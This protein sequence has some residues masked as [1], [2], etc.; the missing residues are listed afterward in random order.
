M[1]RK[2]V[3]RSP[4]EVLVLC[5]EHDV[6]AV[7]LRFTDFLGQWRHMTVPVSRLSEQAFE[8]GFGFNGSGIRSWQATAGLDMLLVPQPDTACIDPFTTMPTLSLIC[9]IYDPITRE[10]L[11]HDPRH[12]ARRAEYYLTSLGIADHAY[13]GPEVEFFI[14]DDVQFDQNP[15]EAFYRIDSIEAQW[16]RGTSESP[17]L[18]HKIRHHEGFLPSPPLDQYMDMRSEMMQTMID[19]GIDAECHHHEIAS[20]GQAEIDVHYS[21][22]VQAADNVMM[23]KY[24]VKN[25]ARRHGKTATFMPQPIVGDHGSGMHTHLSFWKGGEPLFAGK[26]YA[27]LSDAGLYALGGILKHAPALLAI[28]NPTTNS[29]KRLASGSEAPTKFAYSQRNRS[30]ACRIPMVSPSPKAKRIEFRCPDPSCNPYLAF[31]AILM[32]AI[33]GVQNKIHPGEPFDK[34]LYDLQPEVKGNVPQTPTSLDASLD[35]LRDDYDF[36]LRGDVF[37]EEVVLHWIDHKRNH[38][39]DAIRRRPHPYEFCLYYDV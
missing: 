28:T 37:S 39:V 35:A 18:G 10:E 17:N 4:Q 5:R 9:S 24:I 31:A 1:E 11:A 20:A 29:Y 38:E 19:C 3:P 26:G 33:D 22:L 34:D 14:F 12:M 16:N 15:G 30:A 13:F 8:D 32:A 6:R 23:Y 7:D 21:N 25:V 36:L 2:S 27:G